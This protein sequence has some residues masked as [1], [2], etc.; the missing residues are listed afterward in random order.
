MAHISIDT[1]TKIK[2]KY[3]TISSWALWKKP[4]DSRSKLGM[5]DISFFENPSQETLQSLNPNI[6]LVGLN[7]SEK[8]LRTFGNFHPDKTSAQDYKTRF[9]LQGTMFWGAYMTDIIKSYEEKISG[10]VMKYL[11]K[12]KDFE[13][14][15]VKMFE[16]ELIDIGSQ[17]TI[18]V[19]FGNDS[20]TILKR[21]LKDKYTIYKVPH[22]S[23]FVRL[24]SLRL[25]FAELETKI[26]SA[27]NN[28]T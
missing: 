25:A 24:D 1:Y 16:Q 13:Q 20:Y 28:K 7:I 6:I 10:N 21:N 4:I 12:N 27:A 17:N 11:A 22:Y 26:K 8:I 3:G 15:N 2:E 9:A 18:I 23:A 19:A 14:Q 5:E